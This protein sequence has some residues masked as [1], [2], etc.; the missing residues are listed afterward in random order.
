[1][2]RDLSETEAARTLWASLSAAERDAIGVA[3]I[4][5]VGNY[6]KQ[7]RPITDDF[8]LFDLESEGDG[9][10]LALTSTVRAT[11]RDEVAA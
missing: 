11:I 6:N 9:L 2:T 10:L 3:A 7:D 5:L 8:E 1:M 4:R